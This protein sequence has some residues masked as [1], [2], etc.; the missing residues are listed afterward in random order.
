MKQFIDE[1]KRIVARGWV[2]YE[3]DEATIYPIPHNHRVCMFRLQ[4]ATPKTTP[5]PQSQLR[6][7]MYNPSHNYASSTKL[8]R[9]H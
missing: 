4:L 1:G 7:L 6:L 8:T 9:L 5:Q 3:C 2:T